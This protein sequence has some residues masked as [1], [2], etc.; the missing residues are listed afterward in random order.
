MIRNIVLPFFGIVALAVL[1]TGI[2]GVSANNAFDS[3]YPPLSVQPGET[4]TVVTGS[5]VKDNQTC[6]VII[7]GIVSQDPN[8]WWRF[9]PGVPNGH[10]EVKVLMTI[11]GKT[12][13]YWADE[14]AISPQRVANCTSVPTN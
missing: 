8:D 12:T 6:E 1:A 7:S 13:T 9:A 3:N 11:D 4:V 10:R 5:V 14:G 2:V